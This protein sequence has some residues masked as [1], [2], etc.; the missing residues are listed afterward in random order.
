M[1]TVYE[2]KITCENPSEIAD[3]LTAVALQH[4]DTRIRKI[5]ETVAIPADSAP[6]KDSKTPEQ[7]EQPSTTPPEPEMEQPKAGGVTPQRPVAPPEITVA[8]LQQLGRK[9]AAAGHGKDVQDLVRKY[10]ATFISRV[11]EDNRSALY[12]ELQAL[13]GQGATDNAT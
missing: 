2:L 4:K 12:A 9:I 5:T 1:Q 13:A 3:I 11:P 6:A 7:P 10:G 8:A